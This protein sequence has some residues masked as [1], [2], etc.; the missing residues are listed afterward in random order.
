MVLYLNLFIYILIRALLFMIYLFIQQFPGMIM[1]PQSGWSSRPEDEVQFSQQVFIV[2]L[3]FVSS[4]FDLL[5][6]GMEDMRI[7]LSIALNPFI[8]FYVYI[9]L[10]V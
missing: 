9:C 5:L 7:L 6:N 4:Y 2:L 10:N 8:I 3:F 1:P